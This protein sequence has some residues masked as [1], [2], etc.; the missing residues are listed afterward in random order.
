MFHEVAYIFAVST[1]DKNS[2]ISTFNYYSFIGIHVPAEGYKSINSP[3]R[4]KRP[5]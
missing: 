4:R 5:I 1:R 2:E 3:A